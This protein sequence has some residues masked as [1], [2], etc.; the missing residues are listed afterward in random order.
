MQTLVD[1]DG[2]VETKAD[3]TWADVDAKR[4]RLLWAEGGVLCSASIKPNGLGT[5]QQL[6]DAREMTFEEIAAPYK[7]RT[8]IVGAT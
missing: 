6:F 2:T 5:T 7:N 4:N 8:V 1:R 3:W